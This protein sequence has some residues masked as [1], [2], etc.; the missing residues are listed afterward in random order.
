MTAATARPDDLQVPS[1]HDVWPAVEVSTVPGREV[2]M[3]RTSR[4]GM[5]GRQMS[6]HEDDGLLTNEELEEQLLEATADAT[7]EL[8][9]LGTSRHIER[10]SLEAYDDL[11]VDASEAEAKE[12]Q[13]RETVAQVRQSAQDLSSVLVILAGDVVQEACVPIGGRWLSSLASCRFLPDITSA[14]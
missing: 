8:A 11:L 4:N 6:S 13:R 5:E 9:F 7:V 10:C 12:R 1:P 14:A 2:V 3:I